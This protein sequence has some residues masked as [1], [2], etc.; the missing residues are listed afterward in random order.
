MAIM[1]RVRRGEHDLGGLPDD[2]RPI[3]AAALQPDPGR[4]PGLAD[5][6]GWLAE[7]AAA[8]SP[9][10]AVR[11]ADDD[12]FTLP[13]AIASHDRAE[14]ETRA[15]DFSSPAG[16]PTYGEW[17]PPP[18]EPPTR[19]FPTD[20]PDDLPVDLAPVPP[21]D[22]AAVMLRRGALIACLGAVGAAALSAWPYLGL[23]AVLTVSWLLRACSMIATARSDRRRLRGA[24]WYDVLLAPLSAPWY[25]VASIPGTVLL[26]VWAL[27][28]GAAGALLA[29]AVGSG[30]T[31]LLVVAGVC[32]VVSLWV[33]PGSAHVRWPVRV[34]AQ[35]L[36]R[37][38]FV[39]LVTAVLL[40][41]AAGLLVQSGAQHV[42]WSPFGNPTHIGS[43]LSLP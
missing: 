1:D 4:R 27:G 9:T 26:G 13:L 29:Y 10:S 31:A 35:A 39:W 43:M 23:A 25:L 14:A 33:G 7:D 32:V 18:V 16:S 17:S 37:Q 40:L 15:P 21:R 38:T 3:I 24:R 36:A 20:D 34:A 28:L 12:P 11:P 22:R 2:L 8:P 19:P 6:R 30:T 5:I 41:I 42:S